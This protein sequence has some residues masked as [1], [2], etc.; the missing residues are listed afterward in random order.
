MR[1]NVQNAAILCFVVARAS[2][3]GAA[4]V[5]AI[6]AP[7]GQPQERRYICVTKRNV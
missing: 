2:V 7:K 5:L 6:I 3:Y 1:E 4:S